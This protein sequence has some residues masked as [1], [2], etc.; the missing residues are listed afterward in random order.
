MGVPE[1]VWYGEVNVGR[2]SFAALMAL[3]SAMFPTRIS[4]VFVS[5]RVSGRHRHTR[6]SYLI[7][8]IICPDRGWGFGQARWNELTGLLWA[9]WD[10]S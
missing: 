6:A 2:R 3:C 10:V 7:R 4:A 8:K 1:A 9:G 5:F